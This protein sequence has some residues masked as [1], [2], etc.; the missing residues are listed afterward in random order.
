MLAVGGSFGQHAR[1]GDRDVDDLRGEMLARRK[2]LAPDVVDR[3]SAAVAQRVRWLPEV[4]APGVIGAYL[5]VRGEVDPS[6]LLDDP[7]LQ[8]ALPV[9]TTGEPLRF[10]VPS[11]PLVEGP[12]G[13]LQPGEGREV[14]PMS[15]VAVL[16]PVVAADR[17]GNRV[18]HGAGFYDRTFAARGDDRSAAPRLIGVCHDFQ[19]VPALAARP[20]D[21]PLDAVVT[22]VG[23][24]RP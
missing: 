9:T 18:G 10:V 2:A 8:V 13:I 1:V 7:D 19:V 6:S 21:V 4:C 14:D 15:L 24:I 3:H 22:E 20:W 12:F 5:G 23:L 16:V 17:R 11:G